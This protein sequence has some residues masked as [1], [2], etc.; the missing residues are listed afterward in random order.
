MTWLN[1]LSRWLVCWLPCSLR[2][3]IASLIQRSSL[4]G[5]AATVIVLGSTL[6]GCECGRSSKTFP[7]AGDPL[8]VLE[9]QGRV[10]MAGYDEATNQFH[11][12]GWYDAAGLANKTVVDYDWSR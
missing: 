8:M 1:S 9:G 12:L 10:R 5:L 11:D 3:G 7:T 4:L 2:S 6:T